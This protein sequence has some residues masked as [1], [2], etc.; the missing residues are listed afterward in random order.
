MVSKP[1]SGPRRGYS[2]LGDCSKEA[3]RHFDRTSTPVALENLPRM[4]S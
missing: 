2:Q 1:V 3:L 4:L